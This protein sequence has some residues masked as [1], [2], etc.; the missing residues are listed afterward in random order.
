MGTPFFQQTSKQVSTSKQARSS[1]FEEEGDNTAKRG[2]S[3]SRHGH[4]RRH[5]VWIF[6][7]LHEKVLP[8]WGGEWA[9]EAVC[10][11]PRVSKVRAMILPLHVTKSHL[12]KQNLWP[13]H[14]CHPEYGCSFSGTSQLP[15]EGTRPPSLGLLGSWQRA[16]RVNS[17][18]RKSC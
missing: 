12:L 16:P 14:G 1:S 8:Q 4:C 9:K 3:S 10:H 18:N 7:V 6:T 15:K 17:P 11:I 2:S 13:G 5:K